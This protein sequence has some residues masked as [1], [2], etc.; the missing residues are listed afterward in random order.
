MTTKT[1]L[2]KCCF[3]FSINFFKAFGVRIDVNRS[4]SYEIFSL[5]NKHDPVIFKG[6]PDGS[7][8]FKWNSE[9]KTIFFIHGSILDDTFTT[10]LLKGNATIHITHPLI[11]NDK[12]NNNTFQSFH[13]FSVFWSQ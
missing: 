13:F 5:A 8:D 6:D 2:K 12:Q 10:T 4:V 9:L 3:P 7:I 11:Q 1:F